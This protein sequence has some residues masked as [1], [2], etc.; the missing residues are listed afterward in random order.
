VSAKVKLSSAL[1]G[2]EDING[3]DAISAKLVQTPEELILCLAW[4]DV[5]KIED[6]TD[7]GERIPVMRVRRIEPVSNAKEAPQELRD[8][9]LR[10]AEERTG[11]TP[12]PID[13]FAA[14]TDG[15]VD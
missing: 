3:L 15:P 1:P 12:L 9:A 5:R 7:T 10:L 2:N 13:Q 11:K 6:M 14:A 4:M 8:M